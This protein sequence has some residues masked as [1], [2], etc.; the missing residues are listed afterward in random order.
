MI[1]WRFVL[2]ATLT[3]IPYTVMWFFWHN[4]LF[5]D[6]YYASSTVQ[7][8]YSKD[9]QNIWAMNF[10]NALLVYGFVYFYFR[11]VKEN[12]LLLNSILWGVYYNLSATGFFA[13]MNYGIIKEWNSAILVYDLVWAVIGGML[14]GDLVFILYNKINKAS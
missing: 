9:A 3:F 7:S 4:N 6:I 1:N 10:A 8:V 5:P 14:I 12:T 13:F 11:S 2:S